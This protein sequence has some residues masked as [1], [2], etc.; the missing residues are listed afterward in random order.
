[1]S[2]KVNIFEKNHKC[3]PKKNLGWADLDQLIIIILFL[4]FT[5]VLLEIS[6]KIN[7]QNFK[8]LNRII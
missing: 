6:C 7:V 4:N 1:M 3:G 2:Q 8:E 5:T